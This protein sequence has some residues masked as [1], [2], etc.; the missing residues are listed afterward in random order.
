MATQELSRPEIDAARLTAG[1]LQYRKK[2][3]LTEFLGN[4]SQATR[5]TYNRCL[6]EF[7]RWLARRGGDCRMTRTA[8]EEYHEYLIVDRGLSTHTIAAYLTALRQ[9]CKYLQSVGFLSEHPA[10]HL[11]PAPATKLPVR[12]ARPLSDE[13]LQKL[14]CVINTDTCIG[15]RDLA[16][17]YCMLYS[18]LTETRIERAN[19][20]D[21]EPTLFGLQMR[22]R[23]ARPTFSIP[24]DGPVELR[25]RDYLEA[26]GDQDPGAPLFLSHSHRSKGGRLDARSIRRRITHYLEES[27]IRSEG[28]TARSLNRTALL[29][30]L[31]DGMSMSEIKQRHRG[32][33]LAKKVE[34]LLRWQHKV[35]DQGISE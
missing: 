5:N 13:E 34:E 6:N 10:E 30:W 23:D 29:L 31:K 21:L 16:V 32:H 24:L 22:I 1:E 15:K 33:G 17:V 3:F 18:G 8:M 19:V 7:G 2:A 27:G 28:I 11:R 35:P 20:E 25:L 12:S 4:K 26:R 14:L 9:F